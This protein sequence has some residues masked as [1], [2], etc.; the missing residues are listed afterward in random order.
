MPTYI[1]KDIAFHMWKFGL[2]KTNF[3]YQLF[4]KQPNGKEVYTTAPSGKPMPFGNSDI[5]V[6]I[7]GSS[8]KYLQDIMIESFK[9]MWESDTRNRIVHIS[10]GEVGLKEGNLSGRSGGWLG[11]ERNYTADDLLKEVKESALKIIKESE[12]IKKSDI[13]IEEVAGKVALSAIK[14]DFLRIDPTKKVIFEWKRALDFNSN[15]GPYCMYMYARC[16]RIMEKSGISA[17]SITEEDA[18]KMGRG[19][20]FELVKMIGMARD[21]V[22][23]ACS[24]YKPN[25]IAEYLL[26]LS[27]LFGKFYEN[28]SVLK[29]DEEQIRLALVFATKQV[30]YNMLGLL[31]IETAEVM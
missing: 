21:I 11:E 28:M 20:D 29:S 5:A 10:Y 14:F 4:M 8:Q 25:V 15:S 18:K 24:E 23:K 9:A 27:L 2:I 26:E 31:G 22:Q 3:K 30:I 19:Y 17:P 1:A 13:N 12:K 7:I 6:N 16:T